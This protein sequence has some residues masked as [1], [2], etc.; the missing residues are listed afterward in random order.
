MNLTRMLHR[1]FGGKSTNVPVAVSVTTPRIVDELTRLLP[2]LS[3]PTQDRLFNF[4]MPTFWGTSNP[5]A[6]TAAAMGRH[7]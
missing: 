2:R 3:T 6:V 7:A 1:I 4:F 5:E